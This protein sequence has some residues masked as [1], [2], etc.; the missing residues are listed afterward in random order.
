MGGFSSKVAITNPDGL[1][2]NPIL[3]FTIGSGLFAIKSDL[4]IDKLFTTPSLSRQGLTLNKL[5]DN[6]RTNGNT[7]VRI[8]TSITSNFLYLLL[9]GNIWVFEPD[10]RNFKDIRA[11]KY[12]GQIEVSGAKVSSIIIQKN[13]EILAL[14][15][16][17]LVLI[18]FE[19]ADGKIRL[20]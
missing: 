1:T 17:A 10:S 4:T 12:I 13:G 2:L 5:P 14:T 11:L 16:G 6:Y 20:R 3:D 15:D 8:F 19:I 18:K 9:D 7:P